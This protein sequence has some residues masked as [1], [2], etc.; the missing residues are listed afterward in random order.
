LRRLISSK[1]RDFVNAGNALA[2]EIRVS[3]AATVILGDEQ[4]G[5]LMRIAATESDSF[6]AQMKS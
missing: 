5:L 1:W 4:S 6:C 3:Y 2:I